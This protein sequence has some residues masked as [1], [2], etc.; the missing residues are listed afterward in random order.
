MVVL[1]LKVKKN[2]FLMV[3]MIV[4]LAIISMFTAFLSIN[5]C[6]NR[7]SLAIDTLTRELIIDLQWVQHES[8]GNSLHGL[9][10]WCLVLRDK[11]YLILHNHFNVIK[12]KPYSKDAFVK[13]TSQK[14][15]RFDELGRPKGDNMRL[16]VQSI[17][18]QKRMIVIA[19]STGRI[20]VE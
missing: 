17:Q 6:F 8:H 13:I 18:G 19:A 15:F 3:E 16:S 1:N 14:E 2:G 5:V 7:D 12:R 4:T 20:R 10:D 9:D 11:E